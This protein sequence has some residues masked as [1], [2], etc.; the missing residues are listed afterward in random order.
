MGMDGRLAQL[1]FIDHELGAA[2]VYGTVGH[3][4]SWTSPT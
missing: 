4:G 2:S 1:N 3:R